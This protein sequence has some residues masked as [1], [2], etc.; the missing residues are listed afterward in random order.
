MEQNQKLMI[1]DLLSPEAIELNLNQTD[2]DEVLRALVNK[3]PVLKNRPES[4]ETLFR[5][6]LERESLHST[7]IGD[8]VALPHA[9]NAIVGLVENPVIVFGKHKEGIPY[10]SI[11]G[12]PVK[13]FFLIVA[14]NVTQHLHIL[15]RISRILRQPG[16]T[17]SLL[18]ANTPEKIIA[19]IRETEEKLG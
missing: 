14:P 19:V 9:R 6:I 17:K 16:L 13:L 7:G 4:Q 10:G 11:D 2:R 3:I 5:A 1:S 8:G 15:A 18:A 12:E